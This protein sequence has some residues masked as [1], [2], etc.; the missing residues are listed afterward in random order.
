MNVMTSVGKRIAQLRKERNLTQE[1]LAKVLGVSRGAVSMWEIDQR[2]PDPPILQQIANYF[3][4]SVDYLLGRTDERRPFLEENRPSNPE[5]RELVEK[6]QMQF[7]TDPSL[8]EEE[9]KAIIDD[10]TRYFEFLVEKKK[11]EKQ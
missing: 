3:G 2:T 8:T 1:E 11:K 7:R 9:K 6:M 5:I 10:I 4:V